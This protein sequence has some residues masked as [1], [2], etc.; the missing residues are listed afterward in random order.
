MLIAPGAL[1]FS[2]GAAK[3]G[4]ERVSNRMI[5]RYMGL[6]FLN[7]TNLM[8]PNLEHLVECRYQLVPVDPAVPSSDDRSD[9]E[10][11]LRHRL[12]VGRGHERLLF[13][14]QPECPRFDRRLRAR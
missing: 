10:S 12:T 9:R 3:A 14:G 1:T 13:L 4:A 8:A 2:T 6:P 11:K 5:E 7:F